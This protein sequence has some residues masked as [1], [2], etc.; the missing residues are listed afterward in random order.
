MSITPIGGGKPILAT[1]TRIFVSFYWI[2]LY[3]MIATFTANLAAFLTFKKLEQ[4]VLNMEDLSIQKKLEY[5]VVNDSTAFNFFKNMKAADDYLSRGWIDHC[6]KNRNRY[7]ALHP[8]FTYIL[9]GTYAQMFTDIQVN[10]PLEN[11][12]AGF[13]RV[14]NEDF[15][16]IHDSSEIKYRCS[17]QC[18]LD[19]I[20]NVFSKQPLTFGINKERIELRVDF[21]FIFLLIEVIMFFFSQTEIGVAISDLL[22][23]GF[24]SDLITKYMGTE[25]CSNEDRISLT[26]LGGVFIIALLAIIS[27]G[28][29]ILMEYRQNK[30]ETIVTPF[31]LKM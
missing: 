8:T 6:V 5:S 26:T 13:K 16:F 14:L 22:D 27:A 15:A 1:S 20:G 19:E 21:L 28:I 17:V 10:E 25:N 3:L 29:N 30:R 23:D 18:N 9:G 11:T 2:F 12:E 31:T 24:I 4:S 7:N